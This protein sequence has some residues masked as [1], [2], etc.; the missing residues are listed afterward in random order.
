MKLSFSYCYPGSG[1]VLD[2]VVP[3][4]CTFFLLTF[5]NKYMVSCNITFMNMFLKRLSFESKKYNK[6]LKLECASF[7]GQTS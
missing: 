4:L 5:Q 1:V 2:C 7:L 3:D 6:E